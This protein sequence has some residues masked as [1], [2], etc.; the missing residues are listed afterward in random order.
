M[1]TLLTPTYNRAHTLERLFNS[2]NSQTYRSF[3]WL[4]IDDGSN[5]D[6]QIIIEGFKLKA[7][8]DIT[9]VYKTNGGKHSALI[10]AKKY[11][12][13]DYI[14][15]IDSDDEI[16]PDCLE[17]F[18]QHIEK[19]SRIEEVRARCV[20]SDLNLIQKFYFPQDLEYIDTTWH[21]MVLKK[22]NDEELIS[23][24]KLQYY[25]RAV[26]L[27][28]KLIF[29]E[30]FNSF[31]EVYFWSRIKKVTIRYI[32][33]PLRVYH[34]D[35]GNSIMNNTSFKTGLYNDIIQFKY[36]LDENYTY[37]FWRPRYFISQYIKLTIASRLVG[38]GFFRSHFLYEQVINR[39]ISFSLSPA[40]ILFYFKMKYLDKGFWR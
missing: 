9:Y 14:I 25:L 7:N 29:S 2:I 3:E 12:S 21:D 35:S 16:L 26:N 5:D 38:N 17:V 6:T 1:F 31:S 33:E 19:N 4:I 23:C 22:Q 27:P 20:N 34:Q 32:K 8:Y 37:I 18:K 28:K 11:L 15:I 10:E 39:I 40:S 24:F 30:H 36:F 13:N